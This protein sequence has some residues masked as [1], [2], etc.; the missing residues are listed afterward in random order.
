MARLTAKELAAY[1][2]VS[3]KTIHDWK[4]RDLIHPVGKRDKAFLY[5]FAEAVEV[6]RSTRRSSL[7]PGRR[8]LPMGQ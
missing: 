2:R 4:D 5:D 3:V 7:G 8:Y 1:F 6:E